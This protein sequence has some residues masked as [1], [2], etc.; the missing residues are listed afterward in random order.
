MN[1]KLRNLYGGVADLMDS[2]KNK[3][4]FKKLEGVVEVDE[5]V[6]RREELRLIVK[7]QRTLLN[8]SYAQRKATVR[9]NDFR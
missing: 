4:G 7:N 6:I 2:F 8:Y 5:R 3:F 9:G 1:N